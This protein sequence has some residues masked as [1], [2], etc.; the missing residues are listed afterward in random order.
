[1]K[2]IGAVLGLVA[3]LLQ[4][5]AP[6]VW[7]SGGNN[8]P[9]FTPMIVN[10]AIS[11]TILV[12]THPSGTPTAGQATVILS[13]GSV[14]AQTTFQVN[15]NAQSSWVTGCNLDL[16][17]ARFLWNPPTDQ[18]TLLDWAP[19]FILESL[20]LPF[21]ILTSPGAIPP[22]W[23]AITQ[24]SSARCLPDPSSPSVTNPGWLLMNAT[25][26]FLVP[27]K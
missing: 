3:L 16:T 14:T 1:M 10:P 5:Q 15:P 11:A 7:A 2:R 26:Q 4:L 22:V 24:I 21:G 8:P 20:F 9:P 17:N 6:A 13:K 19:P 18:A 25:I 12:D 27:I 23:P